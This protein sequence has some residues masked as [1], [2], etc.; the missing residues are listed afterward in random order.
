[1]GDWYDFEFRV[2]DG[3]AVPGFC[4][5]IKENNNSEIFVEMTDEQRNLANLWEVELRALVSKKEAMIKSW[6]H[7][8]RKKIAMEE[9]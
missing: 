6:I 5:S 3:S 4:Y 7:K 1:M 2:I 9:K 8:D